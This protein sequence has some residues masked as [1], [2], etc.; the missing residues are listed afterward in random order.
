M[1]IKQPV[2]AL[3]FDMDGTLWDAVETYAQSWN[4]YFKQHDITR[5]I[6]KADIQGYM[7]L[8]AAAYLEKVLPANSID[9]RTAIYK[10][11]VAIQYQLIATVGGTLYNGVIE[12]LQALSKKYKLFIVSNC[13]AHTIH[14]FMQWANIGELIT[15]TVAHGQTGKPK[16]ENIQLLIEKYTLQSPVYIGD[17]N[18]DAVQSRMAKVPFVFVD[19]GFG[20]ATDYVAR[21]SSFT[22][23]ADY[24][25]A[26]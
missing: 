19:Y 15:D 3:I 4:E 11:V 2:D 10:E 13:P 26:L 20:S 5:H 16:C 18:G 9:E 8:E 1:L 22:A 12:G 7:G 25:L 17:T 24:Y 21:F 14:Y 23:L 6:N